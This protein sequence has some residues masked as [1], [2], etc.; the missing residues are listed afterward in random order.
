MTL[1]VD[2]ETDYSRDY[3]VADLGAWAYCHDPRFNAYLV[4][5]CGSDGWEWVGHPAQAPWEKARGYSRWISHNAAFDSSVCRALRVEPAKVWDCTADLMAYLQYPRDLKGA[6]KEALDIL[7]DKSVRERAGVGD[8]FTPTSDE[9]DAYA[10]EDVRLCLRLWQKFSVRWPEWE[11]ALSRHTR[12]M[13]SRGI[14]FDTEAAKSA[15]S[16]LGAQLAETELTIPWVIRGLPPTSRNE[17]FLECDRLG[18]PR[19]T[20]TADKNPLWQSWLDAHESRVPWV[21]GLNR[22]RRLNRTREV[23]GAMLTRSGSNR[24]HYGLRYYGA[25]ITGRWSGADGLNLQNLNSKDTEGG[26][27]LRALLVPAPGN[28]FVVSDL[29]QIEPRCMAVLS[30]DEDMLTFLR[31]GADLYEAHA[32]ATMGYTDPR[33]LKEVDK[34]IR[35]LAKARTLGLG[36]SCGAQKFVTVAKIMAG[37]DISAE[38]SERIVAEFRATNPKITSLWERMQRAF[39]QAKGKVWVAE[40]RAKRAMRYYN[41]KDGQASAVKGKPST[42]FYGG[43]LVE[44][45]I[46]ATARDVM[47]GMVLQIEAA[48]FPVVLHVHDEIVAEVPT[49]TAPAAIEEIRR[50]MSTPPVWMPTLPVECE[51]HLMEVYGK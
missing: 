44:N 1:A 48:G 15:V 10:L 37:L 45:L 19:P 8:L 29:S 23:I 50:I 51:A 40:T 5:F 46:Q 42:K 34:D 36:Y 3:S 21:R 4:A 43:K 17:L 47:A 22:W 35:A 27:D 30:G 9:L 12:L 28:V 16:S 18:L 32:R 14:G 31:S 41:P 20:T 33:P 7:V 6:C 11:R 39:R 2:F 26:I 25:A 38:D 49:D 24:L 13:G